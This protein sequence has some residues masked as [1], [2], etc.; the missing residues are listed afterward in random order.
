MQRR[1]KESSYPP[2]KG[3]FRNWRVR[4]RWSLGDLHGEKQE[5]KEMNA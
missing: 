3:G 2:K 4:I 5:S 1:L